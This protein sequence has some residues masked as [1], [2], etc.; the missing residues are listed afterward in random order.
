MKMELAQ[1]FG[2]GYGQVLRCPG[3]GEEYLHHE[4]MNWFDRN[5]DDEHGIHTTISH[6]QVAVDGKMTGN[7][8]SR[9]HGFTIHF[10]CEIC[11]CAPVLAVSQ[12]K[13]STYMEW[14]D[15]VPQE[16]WRD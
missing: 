7:P 9:R 2:S 3:C 5:E 13:G 14:V 1:D 10:S 8:S 11:N 15:P 4:S 6:R 12:H 16:K